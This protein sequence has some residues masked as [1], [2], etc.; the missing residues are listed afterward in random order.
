MT[1][2]KSERLSNRRGCDV[3]FSMAM[4][5]ASSDEFPMLSR[6]GYRDIGF[7]SAP[8]PPPPL[9]HFFFFLCGSCWRVVGQV[10]PRPGP[11][12][13]PAA[14]YG[15]FRGGGDDDWEIF[16][17]KKKKSQRKKESLS[18]SETV[19]ERDRE[20]ERERERGRLQH[21]LLSHF[22]VGFH[23]RFVRGNR[24]AVAEAERRRRSY[25]R[26]L[27]SSPPRSFSFLFRSFV[28]SSSSSSFNLRNPVKLGNNRLVIR[29]E[30]S[31]PSTPALVKPLVEFQ[32]RIRDRWNWKW[33][34]KQRCYRHVRGKRV[35]TFWLCLLFLT[36]SSCFSVLDRVETR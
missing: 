3:D 7:S 6:I 28:S 23:Y 24:A 34:D 4:P 35:K 9:R 8:P 20:R 17:K 25:F 16:Q 21:G 5:T 11:D 30:S 10:R 2:Y 18:P 32:I 27:F 14:H 29:S 22:M 19:K 26:S 1:V 12:W 36:L 15:P 13:S 31:S 33:F